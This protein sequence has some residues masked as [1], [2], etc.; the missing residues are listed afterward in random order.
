M[1]RTRIRWIG[2][3]SAFAAVASLA[4]LDGDADAKRKP[5]KPRRPHRFLSEKA[6]AKSR[7]PGTDA[8]G[9][10]SFSDRPVA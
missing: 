3:L 6:P 10:P 5:R 1:L 4:V 2:A 9:T 7:T 8:F